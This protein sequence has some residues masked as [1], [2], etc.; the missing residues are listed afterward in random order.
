MAGHR[1]QDT[2]GDDWNALATEYVKVSE[3]TSIAPIGLM[4]ERAN[5]LVPFHHAAGILDNG[6]G[7]GPVMGRLIKD[8]GR[9]IPADCPLTCCDFSEGMIAQVR[10]AKERA[11]SDSPWASVETKVQNAMD[12]DE[13]ADGSQSHVT[14]GMLYFMV[15]DPQ[16]ALAESLRVLKPDGV[17][18]LSA[19]QGSEWLELMNLLPKIR[20]DKTMPTMPEAWTSTAGIRGEMEKAGFREVETHECPVKMPFQDHET[21]AGFFVTK[22]PHMVAMTKDM[23]EEEVGKLQAL[24]VEGMKKQCPEAP[25]AL[26][27]TALVGLGRK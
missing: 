6:C 4:L 8:Y 27:G 2:K 20:P 25:G 19:W 5:A 3:Q 7:P 23:S 16:K 22:L 21:F 13:I 24:M 26:K 12:L 10:A 9:Q 18:A 11:G 17:L 14:A 1:L 15:P